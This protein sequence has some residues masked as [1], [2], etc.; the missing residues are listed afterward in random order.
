M[1]FIDQ[2]IYQSQ[3]SRGLNHELSSLNYNAGIVG[4]NRIKDIDVCV[5]L[6]CV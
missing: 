2:Y 6:F 4:P 5:R 3:W 1:L